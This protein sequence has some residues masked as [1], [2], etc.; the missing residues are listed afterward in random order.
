MC[1]GNFSSSFWMSLASTPPATVSSQRHYKLCV[2]IHHYACF[3][4]LSLESILLTS[5]ICGIRYPIALLIP[6]PMLVM[7]SL[8]LCCVFSKLKLLLNYS[9]L[10]LWAP[11]PACL[12]AGFCL[13]ALWSVLRAVMEARGE[14]EQS[15]FFPQHFQLSPLAKTAKLGILL[16]HWLV[17]WPLMRCLGS[18]P[19]VR[20][21]LRW[22]M[23]GNK[24]LACCCSS[25]E[26]TRGA[27]SVARLR[28]VGKMQQQSE[29][30]VLAEVSCRSL[31][32]HFLW[33]LLVD[34]A[35]NPFRLWFI[36]WGQEH[37]SVFHCMAGR[38][39]WDV[40]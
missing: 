26:A 17:L 6:L 25:S 29:Q 37:W 9:S 7:S 36:E 16:L 19:C 35:H 32:C 27:G 31:T 22:Q 38:K 1:H 15:L 3:W 8:S 13:C 10:C 21:P 34:L 18:F 2:K 4:T 20:K 14:A 39:T 24:V 28:L 30:R 11:S 33:L 5:L 23:S 12:A 40:P